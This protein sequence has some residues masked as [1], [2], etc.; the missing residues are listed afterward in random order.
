MNFYH[1]LF[2]NSFKQIFQQDAKNMKNI[3]IHELNLEHLKNA[4]GSYLELAKKFPG[5]FK[6]IECLENKKLLS[7]DIIHQKILEEYNKL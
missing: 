1:F 4:L 3:E 5:H 6:V 2:M 7:I